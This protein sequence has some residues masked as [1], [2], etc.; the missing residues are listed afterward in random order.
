MYF[1]RLAEACSLG[2]I[3]E[4]E[5]CN[6]LLDGSPQLKHNGMAC[7]G[8]FT[9]LSICMQGD[10]DLM[11][12]WVQDLQTIGYKFPKL[13]KHN[14]D[15]SSGHVSGAPQSH[16]LTLERAS[17]AASPAGGDDVIPPFVAP[18]TPLHWKRYDK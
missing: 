5:P 9:S 6:E 14:G 1:A 7:Y 16:S 8:E 17:T 10:A 12:A 3:V 18:R 2:L 4:T 11:A 15:V 13:K